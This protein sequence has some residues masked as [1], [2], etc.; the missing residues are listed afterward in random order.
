MQKTPQQLAA[1]FE[2]LIIEFDKATRGIFKPRD[3]E[4]TPEPSAKIIRPSDYR[5]LH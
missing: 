5:V 2:A 1:E 3:C 4:R